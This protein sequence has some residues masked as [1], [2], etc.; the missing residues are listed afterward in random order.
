[1]IR[2]PRSQPERLTVER[3]TSMLDLLP[4]DDQEDDHF[5]T[6]FDYDRLRNALV[7]SFTQQY[8][9]GLVIRPIRHSIRVSLPAFIERI[10]FDMTSCLYVFDSPFKG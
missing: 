7:L 2:K 3:I 8:N 5:D 9:M 10:N 1:M 4:Y 6:V